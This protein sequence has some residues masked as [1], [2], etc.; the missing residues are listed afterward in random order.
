LAAREE[1][2]SV[3]VS[4]CGSGVA[5]GRRGRACPWTVFAWAGGVRLTDRLVLVEH[6]RRTALWQAS[7]VGGSGGAAACRGRSSRSR[8]EVPERHRTFAAAHSP[9]E[10][11]DRATNANKLGDARPTRLPA[12]PTALSPTTVSI[13]R[14]GP[15]RLPHNSAGQASGGLVGVP[16]LARP[17]GPGTGERES[18][19]P[20][21]LLEERVWD[22]QPDPSALTSLRRKPA[23]Q[24]RQ[25]SAFCCAR[26]G[27]AW[28]SLPQGGPAW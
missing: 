11:D 27:P 8:L 22:D 7:G 1:G 24:V 17:S 4:L 2:W 15:A 13:C 5:R 6:A 14:Y 3:P 25:W 9:W 23:E 16:S 12:R 26:R 10:S 19:S 18:C 28:R 21:G 20:P